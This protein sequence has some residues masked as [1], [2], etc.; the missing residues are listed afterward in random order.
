MSFLAS[1]SVHLLPQGR[2]EPW[3]EATRSIFSGSAL[4]QPGVELSHKGEVNPEAQSKLCNVGVKTRTSAGGLKRRQHVG[5]RKGHL[6]GW[7]L[8]FRAPLSIAPQCLLRARRPALGAQ[9]PARHECVSPFSREP[10]KA[11]TAASFC[12]FP[13]SDCH[14]TLCVEGGQLVPGQLALCPVPSPGMG[15]GGWGGRGDGNGAPKVR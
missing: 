3:T 2:G 7:N 12:G 8:L 5:Q 4:V 11:E 1:G 14:Q 6:K 13:Q 10:P 15:L 9:G